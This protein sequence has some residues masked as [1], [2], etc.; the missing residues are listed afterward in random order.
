MKLRP[1]GNKGD[2][3]LSINAIVIL[4]LAITML[5]L[6]LAFLRGTFKKTTGEFTKVSETIKNQ[7]EDEIRSSNAKLTFNTFEV[8]IGRGSSQDLF[9]GIKNVENTAITFKVVPKCTAALADPALT[10]ADIAETLILRTFTETEVTPGEIEVLK[11]V[12][13][14]TSEAKSDTY[15][16]KLAV[17]NPDGSEYASKKFFIVV[18]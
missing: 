10:E 12:V 8:T 4:I 11:L 5:G 13:S 18:G 6:G 16:C 17:E 9:Y 1:I 14:S 2:L 3:S 7:I 15:S